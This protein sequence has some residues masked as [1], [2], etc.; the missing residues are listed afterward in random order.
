MVTGD[1]IRIRVDRRFTVLTV[2][3][4][5]YWFRRLTGRLDGT[6]YTYS[7]PNLGLLG[8][9]LDHILESTAPQE[10]LGRLKRLL[11]SIRRGGFL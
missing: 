11:L 6:G 1:R 4:R 10:R 5:E 2:N 8:C 7:D 3:S 9:R